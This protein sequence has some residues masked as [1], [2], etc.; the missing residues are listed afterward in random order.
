MKWLID[1]CYGDGNVG[2]EALLQAVLK[3][4]RFVD[5]KAVMRV[6][7]ESPNETAKCHGVETLKQCNP[8]G[9]HLYGGIRHGLLRRTVNAIRE[10]DCFVLGGG[11]LFRD[12][13]GWHACAG[14]MYRL[15]LAKMFGKRVVA[16][17]VG[18]QLSQNRTLAAAIIRRAIKATDT[19][20]LRD[21]SSYQ[22][23]RANCSTGT[24]VHW[25][26][27]IVFSLDP[28]V[29]K[30]RKDERL[31]IGVS[32]KGHA[33]TQAAPEDT[34][35]FFGTLSESLIE[36]SRSRDCR[37]VLLPFCP[38]DVSS[39]ETLAMLLHGVDCQIDGSVT[40]SEYRQAIETAQSVDVMLSMPLHAAI[41]AT[42][43]GIPVIGMSYDQKVTRLFSQLGIG[44]QCSDWKKCD[45]GTLTNQ[46]RSVLAALPTLR[47]E[48]HRIARRTSSAVAESIQQ[49]LAS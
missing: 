8:F 31:A 38:A 41:L 18:V 21:E 24:A 1:G 44:H 26:P 10:C 20:Y 33:L 3:H 25:G 15:L 13:V 43:A 36:V 30:H 16:L 48:T 49:M 46:L 22:S 9:L 45:T 14:M 40:R 37:I 4:V 28:S 6:L 5:S 42:I 34:S 2:D 11:E 29:A 39:C 7:S 35:R 12:D 19:A 32:L 27:D 47:D 23:F 17:G